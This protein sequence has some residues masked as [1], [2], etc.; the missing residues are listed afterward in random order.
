MGSFVVPP[1]PVRQM[2]VLLVLAP[3][4]IL[5][6]SVGLF[7]LWLEGA[8]LGRVAS[9]LGLIALVAAL[10]Y[11]LAFAFLPGRRY[12]DVR[13]RG[14]ATAVPESLPAMVCAWG[15]IACSALFIL[16]VIALGLSGE[17]AGAVGP[18]VLGAGVLVLAVPTVVGVMNGRVRRGGV[19]LDPERV[20][21][22]SW[23]TTRSIAWDDVVGVRL[24]AEP[25][26]SLVLTARDDASIVSSRG[27]VG[28]GEQPTGA[29]PLGTHETS[30][31]LAHAGA[32][33]ALLAGAV[34]LYRT[35]PELRAELGTPTA[36]DRLKSRDLD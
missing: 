24:V 28:P 33:G 23:N 3:L 2:L 1:T 10:G 22:A 17:R 29:V 15:A 14:G 18:L 13:T 20:S 19:V 6:T 4:L 21:I 11:L 16:A 32:D 31:S 30:L 27:A 25:R 34:E 9:V 26:R 7:V 36:A 5:V 8:G 12:A 35:R